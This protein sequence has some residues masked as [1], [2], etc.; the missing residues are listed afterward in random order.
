MLAK[1]Q[2]PG[3]RQPIAQ[4]GQHRS[5][6]ELPPCAPQIKLKARGKENQ[7]E[8]QRAHSADHLWEA[9]SLDHMK[10]GPKNNT[11]SEQYHHIGHASPPR[12]P[13][14]NISEDQQPSKQSKEMRQRQSQREIPYRQST[15]NSRL[16]PEE[17]EK[18]YKADYKTF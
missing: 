5:G 1:Q 7:N 17:L 16:R 10:H 11:A 6:N 13:V 15:I 2:H 12:Q 9:I 14:R 4:N 18:Q 3:H 8:R